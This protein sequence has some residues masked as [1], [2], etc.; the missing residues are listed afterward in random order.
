M[1]K[2]DVVKVLADK[3]KLVRVERDY[4][5]DKMAE[6]LGLSK[7]TLVQIEKGR[8]LPGW[9]TVVA[10]CALFRDSVIIR[11]QLGDSPLEVLELAAH[12]NYERP[13]E[14][15]LGGKVWWKQIAESGG[16]E[17]Q[18]NLIS[19]HYR[20]LDTKS[21]RWCSSFDRDYVL[22]RLEELTKGGG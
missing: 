6:I 13:K 3:F 12:H 2:E 14:Q 20:I 5:Q 22:K 1:N 7:K 11:S 18:Q 4:T 9:T 16:Y 8:I 10:L 17:I 21:R 15:T 19:N